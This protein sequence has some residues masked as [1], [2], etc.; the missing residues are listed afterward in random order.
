M[1]HRDHQGTALS[2]RV[3][4]S[5]PE[6]GLLDRA[7]PTLLTPHAAELARLLGTE[8]GQVTAARLAHARAAADRFGATVLLKGSTTVVAPAG[9]GTVLVNSTGTSWL[10]TAGTGDVLSGLAGALLA[11]GL[12]VPEAAAAAAYLHGLAGRLA[13]AGLAGPGLAGPDA[14]AEGPI[15]A[16][17]VIR[18]LP[19]AIRQVRASQAR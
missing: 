11:H 10:A 2:E 16:G 5:P 4:L 8:P 12:P 7:A 1:R 18:A 3:T 13:A 19:A 17:D 9:G 6:P 15:A 14:A